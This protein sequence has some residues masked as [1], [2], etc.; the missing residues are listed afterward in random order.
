MSMAIEVPLKKPT[1]IPNNK[2]YVVAAVQ[3]HTK[4]HYGVNHIWKDKE[5]KMPVC[6]A[7]STIMTDDIKLCT[8]KECISS[9]MRMIFGTIKIS[10][11][12]KGENKDE[13]KFNRNDFYS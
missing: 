13:S 1:Y 2:V 7:I 12:Y 3:P 6:G 8:C 4:I 11:Q 5:I 9:I 10:K